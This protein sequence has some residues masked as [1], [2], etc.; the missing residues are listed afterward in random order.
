MARPSDLAGPYKSVAQLPSLT[1]TSQQLLGLSFINLFRGRAARQET[2]EMRRDFAKL[3]REVDAF[4]ELVGP[5]NFVYFDFLNH[6]TVQ[7][8]LAAVDGNADEAERLLVAHLSDD[9]VLRRYVQQVR[10]RD[11][12]RPRWPLIERALD[13]QAA[14]R[15]YAVVL[16]LLAVMDG[17]VNDLNPGAR[18]GLHSRDPKD[19]VGWDNAIS[20]HLGLSNAHV[21]FTKR[22]DKT[23]EEEAIELHRHGIVHGT[24]INYDNPVIAAKAWCRLFA[25]V[26]WAD[27][28]DAKKK[29]EAEPPP[30]SL[31]QTLRRL[32]E[33]GEKMRLYEE[34]ME[35]WN[36]RSLVPGDEDFEGDEVKAVTERYLS[37]WQ[38]GRIGLMA[39]LIP[40][41]LAKDSPK[42]TAFMV[43]EEVADFDLTSFTVDGVDPVAPAVAETRVTLVITA[44]PSRAPYGGSERGTT[45]I[46]LTPNVDGAWHV[47]SWGPYAIMARRPR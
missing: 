6:T 45:A 47:M 33:H 7:N 18:Q 17:Y 12:L 32:A 21:S 44:R 2:A 11:G 8:I 27:S 38:T 14:G 5:R 42:K 36:R 39:E 28:L 41:S 3:V 22:C 1:E 26:N 4:C 29:K 9:E 46:R 19:M 43:K 16:V 20:H 30:L 37:A 34:G 23:T 25:V 35:A 24:I 31:R 15:Y 10:F 13:D 40:H